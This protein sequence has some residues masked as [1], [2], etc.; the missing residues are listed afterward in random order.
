MGLITGTLKV[1]GALVAGSVIVTGSVIVGTGAFVVGAVEAIIDSN[2]EP[3]TAASINTKYNNKLNIYG[4]AAIETELSKLPKKVKKALVKNRIT[5][6]IDDN[7]ILRLGPT[8][9]GFYNYSDR[10]IVIKHNEDSIKYALLHEVGH[11]LDHIAN[12]SSKK[13]IKKSYGRY[14]VSFDNDYFYSSV[15]EYVAQSIANYCNGTL[16]KDTAMYKELD[17]ILSCISWDSIDE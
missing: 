13:A 5:I 7:A 4:N 16:P 9:E 6:E 14:E 15:K 12:I 8:V 17:I 11:A 2:N 3:G 1:A 10:R